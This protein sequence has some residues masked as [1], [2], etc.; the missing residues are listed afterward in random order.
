MKVASEINGFGQE[1]LGI[2]Q[3]CGIE[4]VLQGRESIDRAC[5]SVGRPEIDVYPSYEPQ[6]AAHELLVQPSFE[7]LIVSLTERYDAVLL[8]TPPALLVPDATLILAHVGA[9]L[10][11]AR[12]GRTRARAFRQ[13]LDLLPRDRILGGILNADR[14]PHYASDHYYYQADDIS[15]ARRGA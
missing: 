9:C 1:I 12:M 11:I 3:G 15:A 10:P 14:Q 5:V 6:R 8:D 2:T 13:M 7:H 4:A